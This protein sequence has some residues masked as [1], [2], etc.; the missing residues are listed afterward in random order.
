M[1][2]ELVQRPRPFR[3]VIRI[4]PPSRDLSWKN[5]DEGRSLS[6]GVSFDRGVLIHRRRPLSRTSSRLLLCRV[7]GLIVRFDREL[8]NGMRIRHID[9]PNGLS[10]F[11]ERRR[12]C[13]EMV[14]SVKRSYIC[15]Y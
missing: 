5:V 11:A 7:N 2:M 10:M 9:V 15:D 1:Q 12:R 3:D 8:I 4:S 6:R 14:D 13:R